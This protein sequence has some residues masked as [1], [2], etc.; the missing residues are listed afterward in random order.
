MNWTKPTTAMSV[1]KKSKISLQAGKQI[2]PEMEWL[3]DGTVMLTMFFPAP[4]PIAEAAAL[5]CA[6]RMNLGR[7]RSYQP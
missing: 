6:K 5:E 1:W 3:A 2:R 7:M 4:K